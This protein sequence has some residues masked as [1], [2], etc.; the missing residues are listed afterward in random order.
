MSYSILA[1][2]NSTRV[3]VYVIWVP[4][5]VYFLKVESTDSVIAQ[6]LECEQNVKLR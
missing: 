4:K 2:L 5:N 3:Q 6:Q 1:T